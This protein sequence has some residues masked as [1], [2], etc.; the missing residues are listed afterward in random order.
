MIKSVC[1]YCGVGCGVEYGGGKLSGNASYPINKGNLCLKGTSQL[2][3]MGSL[4]LT[5]PL[6]RK[7]IND[8]FKTSSYKE[9]ISAIA[10]KIKQTPKE[11][12]AFYLSGQLL[13]ED[14]YIANKLGKGFIGTNN[15]DTNSRTCMSS[16][17]VGYKKSIG[18]DFVPLRMDDIF[19]AN[20][21]IL[22]GAN[23]A[24]SH[25]IFHNKIKKAKK[26]GLKVVV[27][28][29][30]F[31]DTA[32]SAD[33]YLPIKVGG[34]IDFF[35]LISKRLIEEEL[36]EKEFVQKHINGFEALKNGLNSL[37][38]EEMLKGCGLTYEQ[39]EEFFL[40]YKESKNIITAWTMGLNQS[41]Q[42]VDKNL[43]LINTHL[44]GGKIFKE[45][46]GPLSLTGQPNAM[47]G[48]EVGGLSTMLG[49][50]LGFDDKSIKKV[51]E[52]WNTNNISNKA[53]LCAT[54]MLEAEIEVLIICHTDPIYHL[55]NRNKNEAL[56]QKIPLIVEINAYEN[57]ES[58][59]FAHIRLPAT[60][61]GEKEGTQT[62]LDR[63][64]TKQCKLGKTF[65]D[66]KA[67]WEI[68]MLLAQELGYKKEFDYKSPKEIFEEYQ[69][70]TKLNGY[71]DICDASYDELSHKP[72]VW[73]EKIKTFLTPAK[74]GNLFFVHNRLLSE[75]T[76]PDY[77]FLLLTGRTRDQW[78]SGTKSAQVASLLKYKELSF[79]EINPDD[80]KNLGIKEGDEVRVSSVRG[81]L[82]TKALVVNS[83]AKGVLF[84]PISNRD[85]NYLT[86][87]L[88]DCESFQP[89]YNHSAVKVETLH[90]K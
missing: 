34:D 54:Q 16:A 74:V 15:V 25:V 80:A 88:L 39:F 69:Q 59:K 42:G 37:K 33:I 57:S 81:E 53:G 60:P 65:K 21:L 73:G 17:V 38:S 8:E 76:T 47:G 4:R 3:S 23:T 64:I 66:I 86:N 51:S 6:L 48:R 45:G 5:T 18:A 63:T 44:L 77:P 7:N 19:S 87:D 9:C 28:D 26:E 32:K 58:A 62:N 83:V 67:D 84:I 50:H 24:E 90:K 29:P 10:Q 27:V 13:S 75:K 71:M 1:G 52:F 2:S 43:S 70:M 89:D 20:L 36:Y 31:T 46:N 82:V 55:P 85:I 61:W 49:V 40:L 72:F 41:V 78:H 68:F 30:R 14:Y 56:I 35:N 11:K 12:I 79:C 22:A